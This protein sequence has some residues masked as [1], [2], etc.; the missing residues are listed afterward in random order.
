MRFYPDEFL[1]K[2]LGKGFFKKRILNTNL[3]LKK[4]QIAAI[5]KSDI[6][7]VSKKDL[8]KTING[9]ID[10][11]DT[12]L[13]KQ[14]VGA[15]DLK[16]QIYEDQALLRN[17]IAGLVVYNEVIKIKEE[18]QGQYYRWLPSDAENPDP[19]HSLLYGKVFKIGEGDD[20]GN[21]PGERYGCKCGM[22]ILTKKEKE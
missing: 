20:E 10:E 8:T 7:S 14:K 2:A 21:M 11:Y 5:L 3:D 13:G 9:V 18:H 12:K 16:R 15:K 6:V 1:R 17:R 22:E 19:L 4:A